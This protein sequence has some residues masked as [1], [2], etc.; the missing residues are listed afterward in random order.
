MTESR[1]RMAWVVIGL[2]VS[3]LCAGCLDQEENITV[4]EN[5]NVTIEVTLSGK[6]DQLSD[7][8]LIPSGPE[9]EIRE[10]SVDSSDKSPELTIRATAN[11]PYGSPLPASFVAESSPD[12]TLSLHF[13]GEV[14]MES[15][16]DR[17]YYTFRRRYEARRFATFDFSE[18]PE[19]WD[20]DLESRVLDSGL[21][22]ASEEDRVSYLRQLSAN[23]N[24]CYWRFFREALADLV[25]SSAMADT[26]FL[27]LATE[28]S[29][30]LEGTIT[31][32]LMLS[33]MQREEEEIGVF[34]DSLGR[35]ID[36]H[37]KTVVAAAARPNSTAAVQF[38]RAYTRVHREYDVNE[39]LGVFNYSINLVMPGTILSTNGI[40]ES[41]EPS[42]VS[43]SIKG[44]SLHDADVPLYAVS[45]VTH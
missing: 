24:Y 29:Q 34:I 32:D 12:Y 4:A 43:W 5:G 17:T 16:G 25:R 45:V 19:L 10:R 15:K 13:P 2:L 33:V 44:K 35:E 28:A 31:P 40:I 37:F 36:R 11:T 42:K 8:I 14:T 21:L 7:P 23:Y 27:R 1:V 3:L 39:V 26:T 41:G 6:P 9:W 18:I 20:H 30:Y 38:E 22:K